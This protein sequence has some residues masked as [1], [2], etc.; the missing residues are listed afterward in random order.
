MR[1]GSI[2]VYC[3]CTDED[4]GDNI[5]GMETSHGKSSL[6]E[7]ENCVVGGVDPL[8]DFEVY[9]MMKN[10]M[11]NTCLKMKLYVISMTP[12]IRVKVIGQ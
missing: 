10:L 2:D 11:G 5:M 12:M 8:V 9:M 7:G 3:E 4:V 1:D 6:N